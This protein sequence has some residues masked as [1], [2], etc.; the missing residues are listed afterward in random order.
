[1]ILA[2]PSVIFGVGI[3]IELV[4]LFFALMNYKFINAINSWKI[5]TKKNYRIYLASI[6]LASLT[7]LWGGSLALS[8]G[9]IDT[10]GATKKETV[11]LF[12]TD[13]IVTL[14]LLGVSLAWQTQETEQ[15]R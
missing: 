14:L 9:H 12:I 10:G 8:F 3:I 11:I 4:L 7:C 15:T 2:A 13:T 5:L 6:I 1:M